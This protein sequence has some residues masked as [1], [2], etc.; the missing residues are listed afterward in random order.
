M[1]QFDVQ[2][3]GVRPLAEKLARLEQT[4][5]KK[6]VKKAVTKGAAVV[7]KAARSNA[8]SMV[9]GTMGG[10][11][12]KNIASLAYKK[13]RRGSHARWVGVKSGVDEFVH[14]SRRGKR[15]YIPAAI[16]FGHDNAAAIPFTRSAA[17]SHG[18]RAAK[19]T[20]TEIDVRIKRV[21]AG[22]V[23]REWM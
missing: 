5:G 6:I 3:E 2:L 20:L 21:F 22:R 15:S 10:L 11:L 18:E 12:A 17:E 7:R 4:V 23:W 14:V 16:E 19:V 1:I 9:G 13:Q 8:K